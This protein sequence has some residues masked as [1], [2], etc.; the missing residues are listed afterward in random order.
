MTLPAGFAVSSPAEGIDLRRA[1]LSPASSV[2]LIAW[3]LETLTVR[4]PRSE[5]GCTAEKYISYHFRDERM[6]EI[7]R[8][9]ATHTIMVS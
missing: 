7:R 3:D 4:L 2:F 1:D 6:L 5:V 9:S 8:L